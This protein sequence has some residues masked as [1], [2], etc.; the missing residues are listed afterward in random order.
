MDILRYISLTILDAIVLVVIY[1]FY[2][3]AALRM[4]NEEENEGDDDEI[5]IVAKVQQL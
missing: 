1:D 2:V 5:G 4:P 3:W